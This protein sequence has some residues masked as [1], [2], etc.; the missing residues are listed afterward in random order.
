MKFYD[1]WKNIFWESGVYYVK[2]CALVYGHSYGGVVKVTKVDNFSIAP[3]M[4]WG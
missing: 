3:L 1:I 2:A 4:L